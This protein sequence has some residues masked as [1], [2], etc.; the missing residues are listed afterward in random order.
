MARSENVRTASA[1]S[2]DLPLSAVARDPGVRSSA[3]TDDSPSQ[4]LN[5]RTFGESV[6]KGLPA[7]PATTGNVGDVPTELHA[8]IAAVVIPALV[9]RLVRERAVVTDGR[10]AAPDSTQP[11]EL[12]SR[13]AEG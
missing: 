5:Q 9:E 3:R 10:M 7:E 13:S 8:F 11:S 4:R 1:P 6:K 12:R 2:D